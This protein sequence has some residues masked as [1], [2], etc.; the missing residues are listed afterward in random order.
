MN[1]QEA[2]IQSFRK[3]KLHG[4]FIL[5]LHPFTKINLVI[6][7]AIVGALLST[8]WSRI[9]AIVIFVIINACVGKNNFYKFI[10]LYFRVEA[11]LFTML[12]LINTAFR[13]GGTVY[14]EWGIIGVTKEGFFH[15]LKMGF[16]I[17]SICAGIM[18]LYHIIPAKDMM[19][20]LEKLGVSRSASYII[21]AAAQSTTDLGKTAHTI[22]ESQNARGVETTGSL[23]TRFK[24][25]L[26]ILFPLLLSAVASTEE[27]TVAMETKSF[28]AGVKPTHIYELRQTPIGEKIGCVAIDLLVVALVVW[29]LW[30]G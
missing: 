13:P 5:D 16:L 20:A 27:K 29:R 25:L 28:A 23:K 10:K 26:P 15:G 11:I 3:P 14:W 7:I 12:V 19:Y 9:A 17:A 6:A 2:F 22:M 8:Y 30:Y 18:T 24:A 1:Q 21:M 4:N